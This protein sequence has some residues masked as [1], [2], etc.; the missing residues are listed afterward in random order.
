MADALQIVYSDAL[1][2]S[3]GLKRKDIATLLAVAYGSSL[4]LGT[5][6]AASADYM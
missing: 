4:S 2:E 6:I 1:Y 3:Y 5:V